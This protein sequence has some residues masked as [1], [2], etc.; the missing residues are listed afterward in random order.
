MKKRTATKSTESYE[1]TWHDALQILKPNMVSKDNNLTAILHDF[2]IKKV[3]QRFDKKSYRDI[4]KK[5]G[6]TIKRNQVPDRRLVVHNGHYTIVPTDTIL[7]DIFIDI[8][9]KFIH[10]KENQID[11]VVELGSGIGINLFLLARKL[12]PSLGRRIKF[13]A[14][15]I[16]DAG[17]KTCK[18]IIDFCDEI[19]M[20]V[21]YFDYYHPDFSFLEPQ[22]N[23]LFF[24]AHSIEQIP[25]IDRAVFEKMIAVANQCYC[26]HA[27][28]VGWQYEEELSKM[29]KHLK[30]NH[31]KKNRSKWRRKLV[32]VDRSLYSRF[33]V[34]IVDTSNKDGIHIEKADIG[35]SDRISSNAALYSLAHDYNTNL[36]SVLKGMESEGLIRIGTEMQDLYGKYPFNPSSI[37]AWQKVTGS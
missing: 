33:G 18:K 29:R 15:E 20:S 12:N 9:A 35:K 27:E 37:I 13:C 2:L 11:Y 14:C 19:S 3:N 10:K 32:K 4:H 28:P 30:P 7:D 26:Y 6:I 24:T 8:L 16:T 22:R 36:V 21:E 17:R 34:G 1:D 25:K 23:V 5:L 31:W